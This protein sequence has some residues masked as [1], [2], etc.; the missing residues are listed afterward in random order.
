MK[1]TYFILVCIVVAFAMSSC[2]K[3]ELFPVDRY[4]ISN[5]ATQDLFVSLDL[6][7][8]EPTSTIN[9]TAFMIKSKDMVEIS[10]MREP[11]S[12][13]VVSISIYTSSK[14]FL[15]K[16]N[17]SEMKWEYTSEADYTG[18]SA[19]I[20]KHTFTITNEVIKKE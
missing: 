6:S 8:T 5:V 7:P 16:L 4:Y 1:R 12:A 14:E 17:E 10:T 15:R 2:G 18:Y 19:C 9:D 20:D 13:K 11:V 3:K